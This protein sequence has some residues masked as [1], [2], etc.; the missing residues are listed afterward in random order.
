MPAF[1]IEWL[2]TQ[3]R[4][5]LRLST[6]RLPTPKCEQYWFDSMK[7]GHL[8]VNHRSTGVGGYGNI[9]TRITGEMMSAEH[10]KPPYTAVRIDPIDKEWTACEIMA[11]DDYFVATHICNQQD[12]EFIV[13][14]CNA[15]DDLV[16]ALQEAVAVIERL[17]PE[18]NGMGTIVR[19][20][21]A[22]AKAGTA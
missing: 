12:A 22:L 8:L 19:S 13:R 21:A 2:F 18:G 14:A 16:S 6:R 4:Q 11:G 3:E 5:G 9:P 20:N 7:S 10:K 17:R 1:A 15:H